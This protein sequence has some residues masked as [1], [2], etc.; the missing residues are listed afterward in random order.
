MD[1]IGD[2]KM[3]YIIK[4][5]LEIA[6]FRFKLSEFVDLFVNNVENIVP[7]QHIKETFEILN[8]LIDTLIWL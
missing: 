7:K 8:E 4:K 2:K 1:I 3:S 5:T 6:K